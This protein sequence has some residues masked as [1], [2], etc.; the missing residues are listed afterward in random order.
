[1][2]TSQQKLPPGLKY[3]AV[4]PP[5]KMT[6]QEN[7]SFMKIITQ[8]L[9]EE[10]KTFVRYPVGYLVY[11]TISSIPLVPIPDRT[12][13]KLAAKLA[14]GGF[15]LL[16]IDPQRAVLMKKIAVTE[17]VKAKQLP[18]ASEIK[19]HLTTGKQP[20]EAVPR[21]WVLRTYKLPPK[22]TQQVKN[23]ERARIKGK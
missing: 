14:P 5:K 22:I 23:F 2:K 1:M 15:K 21:K 9:R 17:A 13:E 19:A 4:L 12:A 3:Y 7:E 8:T 18:P 11:R 20:I 10:G 16:T 6:R